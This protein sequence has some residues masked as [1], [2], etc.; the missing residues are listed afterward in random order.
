M[1][2]PLLHLA[3]C[4][5]CCLVVTGA[6]SVAVCL[7]VMGG[8]APPPPP[9]EPKQPPELEYANRMEKE[10]LA[11]VEREIGIYGKDIYIAYMD[12]QE[13]LT[14]SILKPVGAG[15]TMQ[16]LEKSYPDAVLT[17]MVQSLNPLIA[18][19]KKDIQTVETYIEKYADDESMKSLV[20]P[21][22]IEVFPTLYAGLSM[23]YFRKGEYDKSSSYLER[24]KTRYLDSCVMSEALGGQGRLIPVPNFIR[25]HETYL[26]LLQSSPTEKPSRLLET[27]APTTSP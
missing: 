26:R 14:P 19:K 12:A 6:A 7:A 24:L 16:F 22:G 27:N 21:V 9:P 5:A 15:K 4:L 10:I 18:L 8:N 20:S 25:L 1:K 23:Y 13:I 17:K 2:N 3:I 11:V